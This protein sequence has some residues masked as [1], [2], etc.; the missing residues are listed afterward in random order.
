MKRIKSL[1]SLGSLGV[2]GIETW[3]VNI[4]RLKNP[5]VQIDFI[6]HASPG[7]SGKYEE[8]VKNLGC[9]VYY[10]PPQTVFGKI[11]AALCIVPSNSFLERVLVDGSYDVLHVHGEELLG[12]AVEAAANAGVKVRVAHCHSTQLARGKKGLIMFLRNIRY[13][14]LERR[15]IRSHATHLIACGRDAGRLLMGR[16][17]NIDPRCEVIYCGVP[18]PA[19]EAAAKATTRQS[20]LERYGLPVDAVVIGHAGSMGKCSPKNHSFIIKAFAELALRSPKYFLFLAGDGSERQQ[21]QKMAQAIGLGGRII[22][23]GNISDLPAHM[24]H[25]FD[26]NILP[27]KL[28]GFPV[29][30]IEAAAAGLYTVMSSSVTAEVMEHLQ[31]RIESLS[32]NAPISI[33]A[34]RLEYAVSQKIPSSTSLAF[35]RQTSLTV[36]MSAKKLIT[37]YRGETR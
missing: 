19:F 7:S 17:W 37:M 6:L 5:E 27:S 18:L 26:A 28:E 24:I 2:G 21:L 13:R 23:P 11:Q 9:K 20:L 33:W 25:L 4:V 30:A 12:Q 32:L 1:H 29:V 3:L 15:Q 8:E 35:L 22:F 36:E 16:N 14:L 31:G 34:D 10:Y